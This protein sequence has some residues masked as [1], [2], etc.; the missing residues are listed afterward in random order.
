MNKSKDHRNSI[1]PMI[2]EKTRDGE[3]LY[4]VYSRLIKERIIFLAEPVDADVATT[5]VATLLFLDTIQN[6][7]PISLYI[8]S[9]GGT[10]HDGLFTIYDAMH[11]VESPIRT[12]CIGEAY[13]AAALILSAGTPG[14]RLAFANSYIMIH[15]LQIGD[16]SGKGTEIIR[17]AKHIQSW[18]QRLFETLARHTGHSVTEIEKLCEEDTYFTAAQAKEFGLIDDVVVPKKDIPNLVT[19]KPQASKGKRRR[20]A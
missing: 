6:K 12:V 4:D 7:Q 15:Q 19:D 18:N 17:E 10:V 13:S 2:Y 5:V 11:Y 14:M 9:P 3:V 20:R 16:L 8:N 1:H